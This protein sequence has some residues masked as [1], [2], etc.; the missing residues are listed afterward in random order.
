MFDDDGRFSWV[1]RLARVWIIAAWAF[2]ALAAATTILM[3]V[4]SLRAGTGAT[5]FLPFAAALVAEA[6]LAVWVLVVYGILQMAVSG[7]ESLAQSNGRLARLESVLE[8]LS[9]GTKSLTDM[10]RLSDRAKRLI[11]QEQEVEALRETI[12]RELTLGDYEAADAMIDAI[13][14]DLGYADEA[15]RMREE[16]IAARRATM[17]EKI[18][19]SVARI[20]GIIDRRD[21]TRAAGEA[22]RLTQLMPQSD[23]IASLPQRIETA[24]AHHKRELLQAYGEAIRRND[25]DRGIDLLKQLDPYLTAQEAAALQESARGVFRA[26][27]HNLGVQ[28]AICVT[29]Q[30][31]AEAVATGEQIVREYPNSRMAVEVRSKMENLRSRASGTVA[32]AK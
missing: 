29:D 12:R 3:A 19:A 24:K 26:R 13:E 17:E 8:D 5:G 28:F 16:A 23:K 7:Q 15:A 2:L 11:C 18:D 21:W 27:L 9:I 20:Q 10:V 31:W 6:A 22:Q 25:I 32:I 1:L 4:L 30:R 14:K